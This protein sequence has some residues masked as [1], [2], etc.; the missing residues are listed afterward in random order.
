MSLSS[1][2]RAA[3][4]FPTMSGSLAIRLLYV[5]S[6]IHLVGMIIKGEALL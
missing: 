4:L 3:L 2:G 5:S 6:S 1:S